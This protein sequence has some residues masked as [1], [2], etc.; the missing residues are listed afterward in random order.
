MRISS[1][2]LAFMTL[3]LMSPP[4]ESMSE[5]DKVVLTGCTV[6][7]K[8]FGTVERFKRQVTEDVLP[9]LLDRLS[10]EGKN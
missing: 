10:S 1:L 6:C 8:H 2:A 3:L 5:R 4:M 9:R 7:R